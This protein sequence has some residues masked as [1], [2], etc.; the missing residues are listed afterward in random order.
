MAMDSD[1]GDRV[2][3]SANA[4]TAY[5]LITAG[6]PVREEHA[7]SVAELAAKGYVT[8]D[9]ERGNRPIPLNPEMASRRLLEGM[10]RENA[11]RIAHMA[12]LP[13]VTDELAVHFQRAQWRAGGGSEYLDDPAVV[14][15]R[16]DDVVASAEV[17]IL[18]AQPGGPRTR[19]QLDR[20]L[21]RDSIAL[22]RGVAKRTL[23]RDTVRDA[24]VTAEYARA[25]ASRQGG[26]C[27][28]F[29]TLVGP[30]ER[31]IVIDRRVAFVSNHVVEGAPDH[32]AWQIT[33]RA[34]VAYVAAEFDAKWRR[35]DVWHGEVRGRGSL[36]AVNG[37]PGIS[38]A[39]VRTSRRQREILRDVVD[40]RDQRVTAQRLGISLRT[41]G[42]E[43][44][45]L[46][47]LFDAESLPQLTYKWAL[48]P[49]RLIDDS[50]PDD[51]SGA[52]TTE[53]AA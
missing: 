26:R 34:M 21:T 29:R 36:G 5:A 49:D 15:A 6:E 43:I 47:S 38:G 17:E 51:G 41:L 22:D 33:D 2:F 14:N 32:S 44:A 18:A 27:A 40:G 45:E 42:G 37:M 46:K 13:S 19:E 23:Y 3:L 9:Q 31:C 4:V 16:L 52:V 50:A 30:F 28:E 20:S 7:D 25:M 1:I 35:A 24:V 10:L 8:F 48:S 12:A 39:G 53:A 11:E